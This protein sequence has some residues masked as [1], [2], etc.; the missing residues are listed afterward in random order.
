VHGFAVGFGDAASALSP[1]LL[2]AAFDDASDAKVEHYTDER[3]VS[4]MVMVP[5]GSGAPPL[6]A[7]RRGGRLG[8]ALDG[9]VVTDVAGPPARQLE[10]LAQLVE[11][12]GVEGALG[13]IEAGAFNLVAL[14]LDAR[15][16]VVA[17]DRFASIPLYVADTPAGAVI[18]TVPRLPVA[19]GLV[20]REP[21]L[22]ACAELIYL[23]Y[24]VGERYFLKGMRRV[25]PASLLTWEEGRGRLVSRRTPAGDLPDVPATTPADLDGI[26]ETVRAACRRMASVS[27]RT[28][29]FLSGG[30]DSRLILAA[31]PGDRDLP[32]YSYGPPGFAD[33]AL[34][35]QV[36]AVRGVPFTRVPLDGNEVA[37]DIDRILC[38]SGPPAFPNRYLAARRVHDDGFDT[39]LDGYM[40][41]VLLGGSYFG[42]GPTTSRLARYA[43]H[44]N[45]LLDEPSRR[46]GLDRIAESLFDELVDGSADGWL[47]RNG[48]AGFARAIAAERPR[49]LEDIGAA[50]R[51]M[52]TPDGSTALLVRN[53]NMRG[54]AL[55]YS[56][57]QAVGSRR[58]VRVGLPL[59]CDRA[60]VEATL[61]LPPDE[62]AFRKMYIRLFRRHFPAYAKVRYT[63][64]LQPLERPALLHHWVESF[65]PGRIRL[66]PT[67]RALALGYNEWRTWLHE[68]ERLRARAV[69]LLA[70]LGV[71][72]SER[73]TAT[74]ARIE[75]GQEA[76]S[77][78]LFNL[79]AL[80]YLVRTPLRPDAVDASPR[81]VAP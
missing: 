78:D 46:V 65:G 74:F 48:D 63:A 30:M 13:A 61:R 59:M 71:A 76:G 49:I 25:A 54:K 18:S 52:A 27:G 72:G 19:T 32:C 37:A 3:T 39:V 81:S 1:H 38:F 58:F 2:S 62:V 7:W 80:A 31:W 9:Y 5:R 43:R 15:R 33:V 21:D 55:S 12:R 66:T 29:L 22:T 6:L 4:V 56:I 50:L 40:G 23:G 60:L 68:S 36:A 42:K 45:R 11:E 8:V 67:T 26:A 75:K 73:L 47:A 70:R 44:L 10:R 14:D 69:V 16:F 51:G 77:G 20:S 41:D 79:A 34:A 64:S 17:N 28:A 57:F 35:R 24:T 53:F